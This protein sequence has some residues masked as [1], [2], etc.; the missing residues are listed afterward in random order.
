MLKLYASDSF[1]KRMLIS[2]IIGSMLS[3]A[4]SFLMGRLVPENRIID[5]IISSSIQ[6]M[7]Y[8]LMV[9]FATYYWKTSVK[10]LVKCGRYLIY[11]IVDF[12]D[13]ITLTVFGL[14]VFPVRLALIMLGVVGC[15]AVA[16]GPYMM[17]LLCGYY[18]ESLVLPN[19]ILAGGMTIALILSIVNVAWVMFFHF[20]MPIKSLRYTTCDAIQEK[21]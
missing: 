6:M 17:I 15:V 5:T 14:M 8:C 4:A 2:G 19:E 21:P 7:F 9:F 3:I 16:F 13:A 11:G 1:C 20:I 18:L 10:M 12:F